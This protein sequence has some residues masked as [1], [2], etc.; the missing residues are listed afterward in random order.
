ME[1]NPPMEQ[2]LTGLKNGSLSQT[3]FEKRALSHLLHNPHRFSL[4]ELAPHD[5]MDFICFYFPRFR[6]A[7]ET[8]KDTGH[9]FDAYIHRSIQYA[10]RD[11]R[12]EEQLK[13]KEE[14]QIWYQAE[15]CSR[16]IQEGAT[17]QEIQE[18]YDYEAPPLKIRNPKQVLLLTLKAYRYISP[19]FSRRIALSLGI[20]PEKLEH[21]INEIRIRRTQMDTQIDAVQAALQ[22]CYIQKL[23]L[24]RQIQSHELDPFIKTKLEW[25][26]AKNLRRLE[27]LTERLNTMKKSASNQ[28]VADV[29]KIPKGTVD[30]NLHA[31]K[32]KWKNH[33]DLYN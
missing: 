9:S 20:E 31:L 24:D 18:P 22:R 15:E 2:L 10:L 1:V 30:A 8:Y 17:V 6:K 32:H 27:N 14:T 29:L 3:D 11:Y 25:R 4:K 12:A 28:M 23:R 7:V 33:D 16:E 13:H 5:R 19:D 21:W 26:A